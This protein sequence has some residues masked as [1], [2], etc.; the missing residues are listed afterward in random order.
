MEK[1][2]EQALNFHKMRG[3]NLPEQREKGSKTSYKIPLTT[4]FTFDILRQDIV[5]KLK[6]KYKKRGEKTWET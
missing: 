2:T 1:A 4:N 5:K 3:K 6:R